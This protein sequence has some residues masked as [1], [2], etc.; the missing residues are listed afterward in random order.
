MEEDTQEKKRF[1]IENLE[2]ANWA[3]RKLAAIER[4]KKEVQELAQ[5]EI[6]RIRAWEQQEISSLDNS[7]EFFEGLLKEYF[8]REREKDPKFKI[9]TPYGKVSARK[10]NIRNRKK[11]VLHHRGKF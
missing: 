5:K 4:K 1:R 11:N 8:A 6:E 2:A 9:S 3:F 7:K 10:Y